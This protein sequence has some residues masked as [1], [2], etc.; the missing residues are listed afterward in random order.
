MSELMKCLGSLTKGKRITVLVYQPTCVYNESASVS[1]TSTNK[2]RSL[3]LTHV[4]RNKERVRGHIDPLW[5][6][7]IS[8]NQAHALGRPSVFLGLLGRRKNLCQLCSCQSNRY[9]HEPLA[10]HQSCTFCQALHSTRRFLLG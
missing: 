9:D 1:N 3:K 8:R 5:L 7:V 4:R 2:Q 6:L 10:I